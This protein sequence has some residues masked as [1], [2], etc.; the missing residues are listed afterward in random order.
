MPGNY[1]LKDQ[2]AALRWVRENVARFNGDP[3]RVTIFGG[4]SGSASAGFHLLSP[5][6]K[7]LFHRAVLQSGAPTCTWAVSPP[8][9]ARQRAHAVATIAGCNYD[10]S[11]DVLECLR[12]LPADLTVE[13]QNKLFVSG[14]VEFYA[15]YG[16][17]YSRWSRA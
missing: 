11:D 7:G 2:V 8:G 15:C 1:G 4:S 14:T 17:Y 10:G 16:R 5:L 12:K 9:L 6:S 3:D 13:I